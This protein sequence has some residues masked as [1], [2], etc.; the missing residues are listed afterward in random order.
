MNYICISRPYSFK[1]YYSI[2]SINMV[3]PILH[4][5]LRIIA[6]ALF[7]VTVIAAFA[8][9]LDQDLI[10]FWFAFLLLISSTLLFMNFIIKENHPGYRNP[11]TLYPEYLGGVI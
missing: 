6:A 7:M 3:S 4:L 2:N 9:S 5:I 10:S 11:A 8:I 1:H